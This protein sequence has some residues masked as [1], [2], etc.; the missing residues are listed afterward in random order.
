MISSYQPGPLCHFYRTI[1]KQNL[2]NCQEPGHGM[3]TPMAW[4][5][6]ATGHGGQ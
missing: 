6:S 3:S 1:V 5:A 2:D 4:G